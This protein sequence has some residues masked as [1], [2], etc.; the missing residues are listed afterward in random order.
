MPQKQHFLLALRPR[1]RTTHKTTFRVKH[2]LI[3]LETSPTISKKLTHGDATE[4]L[5]MQSRTVFSEVVGLQHDYYIIT[6]D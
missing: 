6:S 2:A 4:L 1:G 3:G 5:T